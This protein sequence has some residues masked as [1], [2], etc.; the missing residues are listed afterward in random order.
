MSVIIATKKD[1]LQENVESKELKGLDLVALILGQQME[2]VL[3]V[4]KEDIRRQ[5]A[6]KGE[7]ATTSQEEG[8]V[9]I[10]MTEEDLA[11]LFQEVQREDPEATLVP[12][13]DLNILEIKK[14]MLI[15]NL[16]F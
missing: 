4:I 9:L 3:F 10:T 7:R 8:V 6:Q 5:T 15:L 1:I 14:G 2:G 13:E 16:I 12:P 11:L